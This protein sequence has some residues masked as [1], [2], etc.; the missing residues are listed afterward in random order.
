MDIV[1]VH[2][3]HT[4]TQLDGVSTG[5]VESCYEKTVF[6]VVGPACLVAVKGGGS[7][8][9]LGAKGAHTDSTEEAH[10]VSA[11]K[12]MTGHKASTNQKHSPSTSPH[13]LIPEDGGGVGRVF[14]YQTT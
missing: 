4:H 11:M 8:I 7:A 12:L 5:N 13:K 14:N 1:L 2:N 6:S 3:T 9:P 10:D